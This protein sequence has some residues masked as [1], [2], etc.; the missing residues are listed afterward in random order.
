MEHANLAPRKE[1]QVGA[2]DAVVVVVSNDIEHVVTPTRT[3]GNDKTL[4]A[5]LHPR[6]EHTLLLSYVFTGDCKDYGAEWANKL[7]ARY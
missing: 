6:S 7:K 4:I 3:N 5:C 1:S 2:C